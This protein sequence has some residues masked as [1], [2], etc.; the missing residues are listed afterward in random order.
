M[1]DHISGRSRISHRTKSEQTKLYWTDDRIVDGAN[2]LQ[3]GS[4]NSGKAVGGST[5]HFAMVS[6]RF[7][8]EWFKS[9]SLLGYGADWP[10][11][12]R[13]MWQLLHRGRGR[14]ED[15]RPGHLSLGAPP[16]AI[17]L[18]C[19]RTQCRRTRSRR[20]CAKLGNQMD[21]NADRHAFGATRLGA[22]VRVSRI[23]HIGL[24]DQCQAK[25]ARDLDS[26][27][28]RSRRR[29]PRSRDG[30]QDRN[31]QSGL[32][33]GVHY[34]RDGAWRFQRARNV[35]VAGYA[36]ETPRLLLNSATDRF[37]EGSPTAPDWLERI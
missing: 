37:P 5:V 2:P 16:A 11:D 8:P 18:S 7:R 34:H 28:H 32:A 4:N 35:V 29:N 14:A 20:G 15:R 21:G 12:W 22:S 26:A 23:L 36:I 9:R 31:G 25:R 27:G 30:R 17:S 10:L 6:L 33:T 13:E 3:M 1:R 19:S 24:R